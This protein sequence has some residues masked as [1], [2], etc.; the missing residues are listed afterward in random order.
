M[1]F[2]EIR[3][4]IDNLEK[5]LS[6]YLNDL[7]DQDQRRVVLDDFD[8]T[9]RARETT[10][11]EKETKLKTGVSE[12]MQEKRYI[13][14]IRAEQEVR[15]K[16]LVAETKTLSDKKIDIERRTKELEDRQKIIDTKIEELQ[17][18]VDKEKEI[19][20]RESII[21]REKAF[22]TERKKILDLREAKLDK[23]EKKLQRIMDSIS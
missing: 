6:I 16:Y 19:E 20:E 23:D 21:R 18:L 11:T 15:E 7:G 10:L 5:T 4:Q 17:V 12:F 1:T 8:R 22:D 13:A 14:K 3:G 9:L 2:E